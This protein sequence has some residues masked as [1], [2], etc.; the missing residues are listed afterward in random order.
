MPAVVRRR[1]NVALAAGVLVL[2]TTFGA[3]GAGRP[4]LGSDASSCRPKTLTLYAQELEREGEQVRLAYGLTPE[5]ASIPG[6][7]IELVEGEC[8]AI[9]LVNNVPASTLR[10]LRRRYGG[11]EH[12]KPAVSIH[13]H[14]V[15]YRRDSDG[16]VESES[17]VPPGGSRVFRWFA[18][19]GTAGYW[20]YHDHVVGTHHGT[21]GVASGLFGALIVRKPTDVRPD[22]KPFVV[23]FG[24]NST[25]NLRRFPRTPRFSAVEGERV[26][27]IVFA[28]GNEHH[29]FHLHGHSWAS[30]RTG[31]QPAEVEFPVVDNVTVGP[32]DSFGFQVVAGSIAGPNDWMYHCHVQVHSDSGMSGFL[33][34][35]PAE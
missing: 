10:D 1:R 30:T 32:G 20:W 16:T 17:F 33:R 12:L 5:T 8:I 11:D 27:F 22:R 23:A 14:G 9:T 26:E 34:V 35:R 13:P 21:G 18:A 24:D 31:L 28:W 19:P 29:T 2:T 6:P 25:I 4:A 3:V 15:K 7:T